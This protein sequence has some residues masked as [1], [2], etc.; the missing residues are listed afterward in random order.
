MSPFII[1][2]L[3][4]MRKSRKNIFH[5][6]SGPAWVNLGGPVGLNGQPKETLGCGVSKV[7]NYHPEP[8]YD[9]KMF[10]KSIL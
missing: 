7:I 2:N 9:D 10:K 8:E 5:L 1:L 4:V 6:A 3:N